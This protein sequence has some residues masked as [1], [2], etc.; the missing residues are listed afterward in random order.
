MDI[1]LKLQVPTELCKALNKLADVLEGL[2]GT[3]TQQVTAEGWEACPN[4]PVQKWQQPTP[5][6]V[7]QTVPQ[8]AVAPQQ[9]VQQPVQQQTVA[10]QQVAPQQT[11]APQPVPTTAVSYKLEDL[12]KAA[13]SLLDAGRQPELLELLVQ[14]GVQ[15]LPDLP[16]EQYGAFATALRQKG[17]QI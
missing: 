17:A 12:S 10:P 16:G 4:P 8:Q 6:P 13:V 11:V 3:E 2:A 5:Q 9:T 1:N 15:S 7:Q 14:F